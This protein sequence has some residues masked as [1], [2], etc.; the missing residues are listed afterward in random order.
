LDIEARVAQ[1]REELDEVVEE[2]SFT[3]IAGEAATWLRGSGGM[4]GDTGIVVT[5]VGG[6]LYQLQ[7][8]GNPTPLPAIAFTLRDTNQR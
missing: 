1:I 8:Y 6:Q 7:A 2:Q 5:I 4:A 3:L